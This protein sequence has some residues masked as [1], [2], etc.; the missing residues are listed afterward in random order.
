MLLNL[1]SLRQLTLTKV[2]LLGSSSQT[3]IGRPILPEAT[4]HAVVE[5]HVSVFA[6]CFIILVKLCIR[7]KRLTIGNRTFTFMRI[8]L[9]NPMMGERNLIS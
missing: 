8:C 9:L 7:E 1:V 4:V 2:L 6:R 5:E 3:I